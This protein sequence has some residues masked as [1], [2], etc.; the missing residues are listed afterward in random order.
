MPRNIGTGISS[1]ILG[2]L[3]FIDNEIITVIANQ[4]LILD[5]DG[6][7]TLT[8]DAKFNIGNSD[9]SNAYTNGSLVVTGG[10]GVAGDVSVTG[11][12]VANGLDDIPIGTT[13]P[14][15]AVFTDL[16]VSGSLNAKSF[17]DVVGTI[18]GAS[19]TVVHDFDTASVWHHSSISGN[20]TMNIT[21]IPTTNNKAYQITLFLQQ[22]ANPY[23]A[24]N[25]QLNGVAENINFGGSQD[26]APSSSRFEIQTFDIARVSNTWVV[27]S[28]LASF[29]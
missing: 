5:P 19:G 7:G 17:S 3:D 20:F 10:I 13:T 12:I 21:N 18:T 15:S 27:S 9:P 22:G 29:G 11:Q 28:R 14:S 1:G 24:N 16:S 25:I 2:N 6:V 26:P 23:Y 8:T 4:Q